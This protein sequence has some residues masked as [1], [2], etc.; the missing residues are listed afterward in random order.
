MSRS[1]M[2]T[3]GR[4]RAAVGGVGT[5]GLLMATAGCGYLSAP[6]SVLVSRVEERILADAVLI[7]DAHLR[8]VYSGFDQL[9]V[10]VLW[11]GDAEPDEVVTEVDQAMDATWEVMDHELI[12]INVVLHKGRRE[13]GEQVIPWPDEDMDM[14]PIAEALGVYDPE[15]PYEVK[16]GVR[17][18]DTQLDARYDD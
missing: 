4:A 6:D 7:E 5:A 2:R 8:L 10:L 18:T 1:G 12:E 17:L 9:G 15:R 11:V 3:R 16:Y 13:P 14:A